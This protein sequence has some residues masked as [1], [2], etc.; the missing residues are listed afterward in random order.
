[1]NQSA[2][3]WVKVCNT[4]DFGSLNRVKCQAGETEILIIRQAGNYSAIRNHCTHLGKP[5]DKGRI[6]GGQ[7]TCP[8]HGAC[9]DIETGRAI[10]GPAVFPLT[11]LSVKVEDQDI[12]VDV[13]G[14]HK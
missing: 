9:F 11:K 8:Y 7:I 4:S 5:L 6:M 3:H 14:L 13:S 10:S 12:F 1:M 2:S